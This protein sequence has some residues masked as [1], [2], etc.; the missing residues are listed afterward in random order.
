LG[1]VAAIDGDLA[2]VAVDKDDAGQDL[3]IDSVQ[4]AAPW[5]AQVGDWVDIGYLDDT[6]QSPFI[7]SILFS[8]TH[9]PATYMPRGRHDHLGDEARPFK[10]LSPTDPAQWIAQ[11]VEG[12]TAYLVSNLPELHIRPATQIRAAT[13]LP[14]SGNAC[15]LG[16]S[17]I[18]WRAAYLAGQLSSSVS[19]GTAPF[20]IASPTLVSNLNADMTDGQH[21]GSSDAP[22]FAR[23]G[24]AVQADAN[25]PLS[26]F[27][28]DAA[29]LQLLRSTGPNRGGSLHAAGPQGVMY[30]AANAYFDGSWQ[31]YDTGYPAW[32]SILD[33][34][35]DAFRVARAPAGDN[36]AAFSTLFTL[37]SSGE[38][39]VAGGLRIRE[40]G[41]NPTYDTILRG[42]DQSADITYTLPSGQGAAN[43]YLKNDGSGNLSWAAGGGGGGASTFLELT[44]T[45]SSY[46]GQAGKAVQVNSGG[47][48][49]EFGQVLT[50]AGA[51]QF[52][53][54]GLGAAADANVPLTVLRADRTQLQLLR[55][56]GQGSSFLANAAAGDFWLMVN[57]YY[58]GNFQRYNTAYP[59]L[60]ME[61]YAGN[62]A[63]YWGWVASGSNPAP[64]PTFSMALTTSAL[65]PY[66]A[67]GLDLGSAACYWNNF[68]HKSLVDCGCLFWADLLEGGDLAALQQ[69]RRD[70]NRLTIHG[71]PALDYSTLPAPVYRPAPIAPEDTYEQDPITGERKLK[72]RA[73]EKMGEDGAD[74]NALISVMLGAIR[75]LD[76][77]V[78]ALRARLPSA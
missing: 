18:R 64:Y 25:I 44:D 32:L 29:Q 21:L 17:A 42:G 31:R 13:I 52:A 45:P 36:P 38:I 57:A 30:R 35:S 59:A 51:A 75:E 33:T 77:K 37:S 63:W 61:A 5:A 20:V 39:S 28:S 1:R 9:D 68:Y 65:Q 41:Q 4:V 26:V 22:R 70:P 6:P 16:S 60:F 43:T 49:L 48:A 2:A 34:S 24:V 15:D 72:F 62:I 8:D 67:A 58:D 27:R 76:S 46:T 19:S 66:A 14:V 50:T 40:G 47:T 74:I 56:A 78:Q 10:T 69:I 3:T 11:Y 54:L 73:G 53:R 23:L 71:L 7:R 55:A 12:S